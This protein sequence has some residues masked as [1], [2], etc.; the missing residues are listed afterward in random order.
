MAES[1]VE[2]YGMPH[3]GTDSLLIWHYNSPWKRTILHRDG[4]PHNFPKPHLDVLEQ[5]VDY[6]VQP[7]QIAEL[8]LFNGSIG[9]DRTR[10]ELKVRCSSERTNMV[11]LNLAHRIIVGEITCEEARREMI[12]QLGTLRF[13]WLDTEK[14]TLNFAPGFLADRERDTADPDMR[15]SQALRQGLASIQQ[16]HEP[17]TTPPRYS[18]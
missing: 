16:E 15:G 1:I 12:N 17:A 14:D 6:R 7:N 3:E 2:K 8:L 13:H 4:S 9:V 11:V 10:G 18:H 5:V